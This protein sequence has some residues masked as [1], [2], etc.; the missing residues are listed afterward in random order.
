[1][2]TPED[3]PKETGGATNDSPP[4]DDKSYELKYDEKMDTFNDED[5]DIIEEVEF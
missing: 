4:K 5:F 2:S 3:K 1:M